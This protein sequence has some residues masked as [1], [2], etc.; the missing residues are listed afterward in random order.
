MLHPSSEVKV[1]AGTLTEHKMRKF[2]SIFVCT[3]HHR[4]ALRN[5]MRS[6]IYSNRERFVPEHVP[7]SWRPPAVHRSYTIDDVAHLTDYC[8]DAFDDDIRHRHPHRRRPHQRLCNDDDVVM[9]QTFD[10]H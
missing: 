6:T 7:H 2:I 5:K 1:A 10:Y 9:R 8:A 4:V 3:H